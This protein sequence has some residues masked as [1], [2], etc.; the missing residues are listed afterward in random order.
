MNVVATSVK[1]ERYQKQGSFTTEFS[2][3]MKAHQV[4]AEVADQVSAKPNNDATTE[5]EQVPDE[6]VGP[7]DGSSSDES[8]N[9]DG[10]E[11]NDNNNNGMLGAIAGTI[12]VAVLVGLVYFTVKK[13]RKRRRDSRRMVDDLDQEVEMGVWNP[14][15]SVSNNKPV[16]ATVVGTSSMPTAQTIA[17]P[18]DGGD[19]VWQQHV[20][21]EGTYY[22]DETSGRTTWTKPAKLK[23]GPAL[24]KK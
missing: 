4:S 19:S 3:S 14:S 17:A 22:Y 8:T 12:G 13:K 20:S 9:S 7:N 23:R 16:F 6:S 21:P 2:A 24:L 11:T 5:I 18:L 1:G 15:V 10:D